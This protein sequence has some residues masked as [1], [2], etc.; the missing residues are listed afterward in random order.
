MSEVGFHSPEA[1]L[2]LV[3]SAIVC[4][5]FLLVLGRLMAFIFI[6]IFK[7]RIATAVRASLCKSCPTL[8]SSFPSGIARPR[9]YSY[10]FQLYY[11]HFGGI[12]RQD[13][14]SKVINRQTRRILSATA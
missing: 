6:F 1:K 14:P 10:A 7:R 12:R 3:A 11:T 5:G 8:E 9:G 2:M 13:R 4:V